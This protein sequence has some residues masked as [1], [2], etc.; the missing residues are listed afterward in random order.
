MGDVER[1]DTLGYAEVKRKPTGMAR[2]AEGFG[3]L[4]IPLMALLFLGTVP[5]VL[6]VIFGS[7]ALVRIGRNPELGGKRNALTGLILGCVALL[8]GGICAASLNGI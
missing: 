6:A 4:S 7:W 1:D 3:I 2:A 5:A 8:L